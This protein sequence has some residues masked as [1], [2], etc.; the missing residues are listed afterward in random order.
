MQ[1]EWMRR[2]EGIIVLAEPIHVTM[3]PDR[4]IQHVVLT[5]AEH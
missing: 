2:T 3:I 4:G 1:P 5:F